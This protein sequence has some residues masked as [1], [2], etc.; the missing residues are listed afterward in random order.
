MIVLI[1]SNNGQQWEE[2]QTWISAVYDLPKRILKNLQQNYLNYLKLLC[3][4][5]GIKESDILMQ[6]T[7]LHG[8]TTSVY[9]K[10]EKIKNKNSIFMYINSL[11]Y[12]QLEF[13]EIDE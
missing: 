10:I 4:E 5:S 12:K 3:I 13:I 1:E 9:K 11:G 7:Y 6:E 8:R 2:Y